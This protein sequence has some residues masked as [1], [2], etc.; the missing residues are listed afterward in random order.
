MQLQSYIPNFVDNMHTSV[1]TKTDATGKSQ[2]DHATVTDYSC[3]NL[4]IVYNFSGR[5]LSH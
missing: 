1:T 2:L 5:E 3:T 4:A